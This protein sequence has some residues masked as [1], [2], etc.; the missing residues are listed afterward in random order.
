M[1]VCVNVCVGDI[2]VPMYTCMYACEYACVY[3]WIWIN[4]SNRF[5]FLACE[6]CWLIFQ[7][8]SDFMQVSTK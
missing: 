7:T 8:D 1:Q 5:I 3:V 4:G 6:E 2:S